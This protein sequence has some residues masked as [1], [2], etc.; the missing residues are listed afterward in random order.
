M[1]GPPSWAMPY[2]LAELPAWTSWLMVSLLMKVTL[3]PVTY[4]TFI[5][6]DWPNAVMF[7]AAAVPMLTPLAI[8]MSSSA[9]MVRPSDADEVIMPD[10]ALTATIAEVVA[11]APGATVRSTLTVTGLA[12]VMLTVAG[13]NTAEMPAGGLSSASVTPPVRPLAGVNVS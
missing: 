2:V 12:S 3:R 7:G 6:A 13:V 10:V 4:F 5:T 11:V 1:S 8:W 9:G